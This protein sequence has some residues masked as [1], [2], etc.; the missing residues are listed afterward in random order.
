MLSSIKKNIPNEEAMQA[1]A[2]SVA[3]A[4]KTR[5]I[6]YLYG[7]LGAGKTTFAR[8]L[9]RGLGYEGKVKSPTYTL[10]EP[11]ELVDNTVFHFDLYRVNTPDELIH[12][13][14]D[15]YFAR[16]AICLIEWPDKG[17]PFLAQADIECHIE[18]NDTD[19][20]VNFIAL[21]QL[22]SDI[23]QQL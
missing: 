16:P 7:E 15:D 23:L 22:G 4:I 10:V 12:I 14:I 5:A 8:G 9:L 11:Y 19:R 20:E 1:L 21:T 13:G 3:K 6:I 17:K 18:F 2:A